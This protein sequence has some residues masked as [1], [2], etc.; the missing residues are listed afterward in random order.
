MR[1]DEDEG[2]GWL[3]VIPDLPG[4]ASIFQS[5]PTSR[6]T[7][8][9]CLRKYWAYRYWCRRCLSMRSRNASGQSGPAP[10]P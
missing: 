8:T 5:P 9:E 2:G 1:S 4:C 3:A 6:K 7:I 10:H